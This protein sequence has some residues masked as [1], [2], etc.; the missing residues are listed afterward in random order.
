MPMRKTFD[1]WLS[2]QHPD[3]FRVSRRH[4]AYGIGTIGGI[5]PM[6]W[7][8]LLAWHWAPNDNTEAASAA[9]PLFTDPLGLAS[10][11]DPCRGQ[12]WA[13]LL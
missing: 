4:Q 5:R 6:I 2:R 8:S 3:L 11:I 10:S 1:T 9:L 13:R 7:P 12:K